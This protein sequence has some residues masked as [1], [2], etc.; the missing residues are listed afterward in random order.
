M[1]DKKSF[2]K[3]LSQLFTNFD[4]VCYIYLH[5]ETNEEK[6]MYTTD[7]RGILNNYATEPKIHY[8]AYPSS[9]Q[10]ARY[11]LQG[12]IATIFVTALVLIAFTVS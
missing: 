1:H 3:Y 2:V 8:T 11:A 10:Q 7:D 9:E 5:R 6:T 4:K 12:A